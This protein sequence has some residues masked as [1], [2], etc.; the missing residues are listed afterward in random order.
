MQIISVVF[1]L[2]FL[3]A[4]GPVES[5]HETAKSFS[6]EGPSQDGKYRYLIEDDTISIW[7]ATGKR[8]IGR[9]P[10]KMRNAEA[11][12][13]AENNLLVVGSCGSPCEVALLLTPRG[14]Q[15]ATL[16]HPAIS[17]DGR[18]ALDLDVVDLTSGDS[19][20]SIVD[21]RN[22]RKLRGPAMR[23]GLFLCTDIVS[24]DASIEFA[25]CGN[26]QTISVR[27]PQ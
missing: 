14:R 11:R 12:F 6:I 1:L 15:L 7:S 4:E 23:R 9:V 2:A 20:V 24:A 8:P 27:L 3:G 19:M 18:F 21:L 25:N 10:L 5:H 13:V 17:R 16:M 22:G 26:G